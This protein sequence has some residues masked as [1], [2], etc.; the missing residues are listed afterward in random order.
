MDSLS[1]I[2]LG[3][4]VVV[5]T[6]GRRTAVWKAAL[7]GGVV[8]TLPDQDVRITHGEPHYSFAF[9]VAQAV[10]GTGPV[11]S[12][13]EWLGRRILGAPLPPPR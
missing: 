3:A 7:W 2:S 8:G 1:Q 4:A 13:L 12:A 5:A 10:G 6:M 11:A 9:A